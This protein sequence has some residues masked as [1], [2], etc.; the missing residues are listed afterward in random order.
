VTHL[1]GWLSDVLAPSA[2]TAAAAVVV[3]V[4]EV[5]WRRRVLVGG[6]GWLGDM[7]SNGVAELLLELN[8]VLGRVWAAARPGLEDGAAAAAGSWVWVWVWTVEVES[9]V[10][11]DERRSAAHQSCFSAVIAWYIRMSLA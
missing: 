9:K 4:V 1:I 8:E 6:G 7:R 10:E 2:T 3:E 11:S 5:A